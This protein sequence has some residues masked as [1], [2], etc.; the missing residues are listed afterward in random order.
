[1]KIGEIEESPN[2]NKRNCVWI[3]CYSR[4]VR[5]N[6]LVIDEVLTMIEKN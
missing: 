1:M 4:K 2:K 5:I 3:D 6:V